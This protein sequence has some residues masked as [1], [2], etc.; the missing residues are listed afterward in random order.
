MINALNFIAQTVITEILLGDV[1][2]VEKLL[3]IIPALPV[4]F[5]VLKMSQLLLITIILPS[6]LEIDLD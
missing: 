4:I 2:V 6:C 3:E 5:K 1:K